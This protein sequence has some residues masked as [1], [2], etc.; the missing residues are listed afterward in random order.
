M[1]V[2]KE[3]MSLLIIWEA[4]KKIDCI[5]KYRC[6]T[7]V[8]NTR[9]KKQVQV[10]CLPPTSAS[11]HQYLYRAFYQVQAWLGNQPNPEDWGWKLTDNILELIQTILPPA[12]E[13][14]LNTIFCH[15]K[16]GCNT[17][18]DCRT[19]GLSCSPACINCQNQSCSNVQSNPKDED[20]CDIDEKIADSSSVEQFVDIQQEEEKEEEIEEDMTVEVEFEEYESD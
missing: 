8:K 14:I 19:V 9:N 17:K 15:C 6:L 10:S 11:A 4:P 13:K 12:P 3:V 20:S 1:Q 18:C 7:F 2:S 5:D 16:K